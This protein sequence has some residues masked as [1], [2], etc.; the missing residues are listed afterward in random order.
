MLSAS[1]N[2]AQPPLTTCPYTVTWRRGGA[3]LPTRGAASCHRPMDS[4]GQLDDQEKLQLLKKAYRVIK[5]ELERRDESLAAE[6][7]AHQRE[8]GLLMSRTSELQRELHELKEEVRSAGRQ[9]AA[10]L[11]QLER[12]KPPEAAPVATPA[13]DAVVSLCADSA[14][15]ASASAPPASAS[16]QRGMEWADRVLNARDV[17]K[18]AISTSLESVSALAVPQAVQD[19]LELQERMLEAQA[20]VQQSLMLDVREEQGR[21]LR[22]E[23][24]LSAEQATGAALRGTA[25]AAGLRQAEAEARLSEGEAAQREAQREAQQREAQ[26]EARREAQGSSQREGSQAAQAMEASLE[27][28]AREHEDELHPLIPRTPLTPPL[29]GA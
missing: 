22:A 7:A 17:F 12:D 23:A 11:Q 1:P 18:S 8:R 26:R 4:S 16:Y 28:Q 27:L 25:Q 20:Q 15:A 10:R 29:T 13:P 6:R 14:G 5:Q 21:R 2:C 19:Q 24:A 3:A 9:A